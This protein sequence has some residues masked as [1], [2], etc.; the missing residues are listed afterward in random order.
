MSRLKVL[1]P[2]GPKIAKLKLPKSVIKKINLEV[3]RITKIKRLI[4]KYDY[5]KSLVGQVKQEIQLPSIFI[6][7]NIYKHISNSIKEYVKTSTGKSTKKVKIIN[8]WIVRQYAHEYNPV[9][10]HDGHV[11]GVGYLKLPKLFNNDKKKLKTNGSIDFINGSKMFLSNSVF[12]HNPKVG[13]AILFPNY[14]MHT[15]YPFS[16]EGERRSFSFNVEIDSNIA[17]V[18]KK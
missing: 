14:L 3:D 9:H 12:N 5:S 7:R 13:D 2:F 4:K 1:A 16:V 17:N 8:F 15:A 18:F 10:Y 6:K 11:S